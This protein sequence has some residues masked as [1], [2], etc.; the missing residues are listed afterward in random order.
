MK[1]ADIPQLTR[2]GHYRV[3]QSWQYLEDTLQRYQEA[4]GINLEPDFQRSHVWTKEQQTK[5]VEF[6]LRGG[7]GS[8]DI[9]FNCV[10]WMK[11][12]R[13]PFVIVDG[14]QR[15]EAVRRFLRNDLP[16]FGGHLLSDFE[17]HMWILR[18]DFIFVINDLSTRADVLQWYLDINAGGV[19][20]TQDELANV[21]KL[22]DTELAGGVN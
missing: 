20:H 12:F 17:D 4:H 6:S 9:R 5:Y 13:G 16:I 15:L 10:G 21:R 11:D 8:S 14:K 2:D 1:F 18:P 3:N 19:V 7:V 22:L